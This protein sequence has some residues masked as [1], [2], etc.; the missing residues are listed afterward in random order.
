MA[1]VLWDERYSVGV[2]ALDCDHIIIASLI[3]HVDEV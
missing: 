1:L 2:E 3:N